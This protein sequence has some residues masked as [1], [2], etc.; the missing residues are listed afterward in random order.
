[1]TTRTAALEADLAI[2]PIVNAVAVTAVA[3]P[4]SSV[5]GAPYRMRVEVHGALIT[6][7]FDPKLARSS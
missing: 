5:D 6:R 7:A 1:M 2:A 4:P 3:V